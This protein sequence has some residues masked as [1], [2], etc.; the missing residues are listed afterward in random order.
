[1]KFYI[2]WKTKNSCGLLKKDGKIASFSSA[3]KAMEFALADAENYAKKGG[4]HGQ[5]P[6]KMKVDSYAPSKISRGVVVMYDTDDCPSDNW[7]EYMLESGD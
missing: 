2:V 7:I 6:K 5:D 4:F 3:E 1:M